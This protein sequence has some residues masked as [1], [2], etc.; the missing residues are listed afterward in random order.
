MGESSFN[1]VPSGAAQQRIPEARLAS[2]QTS[3]EIVGAKDSDA[4]YFR[5]LEENGIIL[6]PSQIRAVRHFRGPLLTLA[7]AGSGKTSVLICRTGYLLSVRRIDPREILLLTFSSKAAAEMRDRIAILPGIHPQDVRLLQARTFHSFFLQLLR[8]QGTELEIWSETRRQHILLKQM[9]REMGLQD[10]YQPESLLSILSSYKTQLI[11]IPDMPE[12]SVTEREIKRILMQYEQW[13]VDHEK[14]DFDDVLVLAYRMLRGKPALLRTLQDRFRYIMVDEFQ[15]TNHLQYELVKMIAAPHHDL[16]VVG[17]D[18]Q[19]IYSFNGARSEY[20]LQFEKTYPEA[21][22]ITLD[23]NYRSGTRIV[24]LGNEVIRHNQHRR[25]KTLLAVKSGTAGPMYMRPLTSDDEA[26]IALDRI[27]HEVHTS[28]R[29]F[30]DYAILYRASSNNRAMLEQLMIRE[31]PYIEYGDGQLLYEHS[32]V[33]PL[34]DHLRLGLSRRD[35][36]AMESVLPT[37][38]INR[39]RGMSHIVEQESIRAKKGPLVH[40]LTLSGLKD[41]QLAKIKDRL[42]LIRS[43]STMRPAS[44]IALMREKFYNAYVEA[45]DRKLLTQH[46]EMIKEMLDELESSA[47]RFDTVEAFLGFIH[48]VIQKSQENNSDKSKEQGNRVA[49]MTI[50]RSKGLEFPVVLL[51]SAI[52]GSLPHSS[53]LD[54]DRLN[55]TAYPDADRA[56]SKGAA[57]LEE[58]RRLA[59]VAITRAKEELIISSPARYR[60]KKAAVS[61]FL[62]SAFGGEAEGTGTRASS[63]ARSSAGT[64][65]SAA[66]ARREGFASGA[67]RSRSG[68]SAAAARRM[69]TVAA[70]VCQ[71]PGCIAWTRIAAREQGLAAKACPLC[72]KPMHRGS[73][74][75]PR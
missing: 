3:R 6:N 14:M 20:I 8:R 17:D 35:F 39:E 13:K 38:Y 2:A 69:E 43:L 12:K 7:G 34:V 72:G 59:Y 28:R 45:D 66:L 49:L 65:S 10:A 47:E 30:G 52:E 26:R 33:L 25:S 22:V 42:E 54:A 9:M 37:L 44:A 40:L 4:A 27:E 75:V 68:G 11:E 61:R 56:G 73:K 5:T 64:P 16:M 41:F 53:A 23:I 63:M 50:H 70:W 58:E 74:D 55:D 29:T 67:E 31:I 1:K 32:L 57:A 62:L 18:D 19:T 36:T 46:K 60:G 71:G 21:H 15:D 48:D 51:I 24:G